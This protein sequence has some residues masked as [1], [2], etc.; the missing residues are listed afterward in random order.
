[1]VYTL[2]VLAAAPP[3]PELG[4]LLPMAGTLGVAGSLAMTAIAAGCLWVTT[5]LAPARAARAG[6]G[7][8]R[9]G[10]GQGRGPLP[11]IAG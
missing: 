7:A 10:E 6:W 11:E 1:V 8:V 3:T 4:R 2:N 5:S 9:E